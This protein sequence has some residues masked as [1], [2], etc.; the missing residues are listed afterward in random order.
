[1]ALRTADR[2]RTDLLGQIQTE[3]EIARD[4]LEDAAKVVR[5]AAGLEFEVSKDEPFERLSAA[6]ARL[7]EYRATIL[8]LERVKKMIMDTS[9]SE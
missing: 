5:V 8:V 6:E 2:F 1:V 4:D 7:R 3:L 9:I